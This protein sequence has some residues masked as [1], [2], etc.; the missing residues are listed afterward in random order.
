MRLSELLR[1]EVLD[2]EGASVGSV[3]DVRAVQDG[4]IQP[5][6][7]AALRID[8]LVVGRRGIAFRL[9]FHRLQVRGPWLLQTVFGRLERRSRYVEWDRVVACDG[10]TIR[11]RGRAEAL[12]N[13][14]PLAGRHRGQTSRE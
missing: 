13:P 12:T 11:I 9:G 1:S 10:G 8:G 14:P 7:G 4:P 3:V 6:F 2:E 5:N